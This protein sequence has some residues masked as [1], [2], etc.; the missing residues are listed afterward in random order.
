MRT[1]KIIYLLLIIFW[2]LLS[3]CFTLYNFKT[4]IIDAKEWLPLSDYQKRHKIFGDFY[5]FVIF[6]NLRTE[7]N[8]SILF[9][10]NYDMMGLISRYYTYPRNVYLSNDSQNSLIASINKFNYDYIATYNKE[11]VINGYNKISFFESKN[12]SNFGFLYKRK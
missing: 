2:I 6:V 5:D 10:S 7:I 1:K 11:L 9:Y 4:L 12:N 8:S 3:F